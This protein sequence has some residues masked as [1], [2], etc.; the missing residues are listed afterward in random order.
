MGRTAHHGEILNKFLMPITGIY[1][2]F[3]H[4]DYDIISSELP[5]RISPIIL[6]RIF[7]LVFHSFNKCNKPS[8]K[9]SEVVLPK[10]LNL[11]VSEMIFLIVNIIHLKFTNNQLCSIRGQFGWNISYIFCYETAFF[12][13]FV[14]IWQDKW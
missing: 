13:Y 5:K 6:S 12:Y 14:K 7:F 8:G 1:D 10:L 3:N 11:F 2:N 4:N 9:S